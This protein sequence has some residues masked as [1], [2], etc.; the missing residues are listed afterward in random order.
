VSKEWN[1]PRRKSRKLFSLLFALCLAFLPWGMKCQAAEYSYTVTFYPGNHGRFTGVGSISVQSSGSEASVEV[2]GQ[3]I[4]VSGLR[5]GDM[6]SFDAAMDGAVALEEGSQY[7]VKGIRLSGRDNN[8]VDTSAFRVEG[9]RDYVVA[10]GIR[11][12][13][14]SYVVNYQDETGNTLASSRNYYGNVGDKPVVAF[15]YMEGYEPRAYNLTKT[16]VSNEAENV[17]TFVYRR[18]AASGGG[19]ESGGGTGGDSPAGGGIGTGDVVNPGLGDGGLAEGT[20]PGAGG[21]IGG[22][23]NEGGNAGAAGGEDADTAIA[24]NNADEANAGQAGAEGDEGENVELSD[25]EIPL[26]LMELDD[27]EVPLAN[28]FLDGRPQME[29]GSRIFAASAVL[30]AVS[31]GVLLFFAFWMKRHSKNKDE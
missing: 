31:V 14:V 5:N 17:F 16:L 23:G 25:E 9:D 27:E 24:D 6:V 30:V 15:L 8:T 13:M 3:A 26:D 28:N 11:G 29:E 18:V 22:N 10:Y 4:K 21:G 7:Y 12:D 1:K 19:N 20:E 2:V